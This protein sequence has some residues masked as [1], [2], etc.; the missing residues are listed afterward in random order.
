MSKGKKHIPDEGT[1]APNARPEVRAGS[2]AF[3]PGPNSTLFDEGAADEALMRAVSDQVLGQAETDPLA[4]RP[5]ALP[6]PSASSVDLGPSGTDATHLNLKGALDDTRPTPMV[7]RHELEAQLERQGF[8]GEDPLDAVDGTVAGAFGTEG[9]LP[10]PAPRRIVEPAETTAPGVLGAQEA[11]LPPSTG[12]RRL[13]EDFA[14]PAG[15]TRPGGSASE[16]MVIPTELTGEISEE[17][18]A[19]R[20]KMLAT[21]TFVPESPEAA[22]PAPHRARGVPKEESLL[23]RIGQ[24]APKRSSAAPPPAAAPEGPWSFV[25]RS[26]VHVAAGLFVVVAFVLLVAVVAVKL[27]KTQSPTIMSRPLA[28]PPG[29]R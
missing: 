28:T 14:R 13:V 24:P 17:V 9:S 29:A 16:E 25:T 4:A 22:S 18:Q 7:N 26:R 5:D 8:R 2:G 12:V 19:A 11:S 10:R 15:A 23:E 1:T 21:L 6:A 3:Q 27:Q 20:P